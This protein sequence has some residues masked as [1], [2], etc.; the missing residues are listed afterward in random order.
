MVIM[1]E[2][3]PTTYKTKTI[4]VSFFLF[5]FM[6]QIFERMKLTIHIFIS[7]CFFSYNFLI[8]NYNSTKYE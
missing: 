1:N 8:E 4:N 6:N 3:Q 2:S 7:S 5:F